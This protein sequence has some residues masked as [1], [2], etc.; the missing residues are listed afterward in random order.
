MEGETS[1]TSYKIVEYNDTLYQIPIRTIEQEQVILFS[2]VQLLL[3]NA[4]ALLSNSKLIPFKLDPN[5]QYTELIPKR[6]SISNYSEDVWDVHV[7]IDYSAHSLLQSNIEMQIKMD[8]LVEKLECILQQQQQQQDSR[9]TTSGDDDSSQHSVPSQGIE[10]TEQDSNTTVVSTTHN[11]EEENTA[12]Q[13]QQ[14]EEQERSHSPPPAFSSSSHAA[15][16]SSSS[17]HRHEAP[18]SY[19]TSVLSTIKTLN[20][21]L[22]LY[23][24]HIF[25]RHKS[26]KWLAKRAEWISRVPNSIEEVAYQLV[27]LEMALLWTAVTESW[28]QERETWL[29]LVASARSER[30]LAGA[31]INLERH[32][33]VMDDD[34]SSIRERWINE[35][36]EMVVLPLSHG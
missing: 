16:P 22:C 35:L 19:E 34:W 30:H 8:Q 2:D 18:P 14:E 4:T 36:L 28:I 5:N 17:S 12:T 3:P 6:I 21:K 7:P 31:I 26:P 1:K 20:S 25:N 9:T 33:L 11:T 29:T 23:E 27:Q 10:V 32:T 13:Q 24:S 15:P